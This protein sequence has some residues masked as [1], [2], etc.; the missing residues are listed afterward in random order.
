VWPHDEDFVDAYIG[1]AGALRPAYDATIYTL[2][3]FD[4]L[5]SRPSATSDPT[6]LCGLLVAGGM[7][8]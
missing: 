6:R 7:A 3:L 1:P 5:A 4:E 8:K 2:S